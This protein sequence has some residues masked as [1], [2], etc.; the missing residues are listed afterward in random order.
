MNNNS[1][2]KNVSI[3]NLIHLVSHQYSFMKKYRFTLL[4]SSL[5]FL[6]FT[7]CNNAPIGEK[8]V[9]KDA[10]VPTKTAITKY[11]SLP[12]NVNSCIINWQG[13]KKIGGGH[14]GIIFIKDGVALIKEGKLVGGKITINMN[15]LIDSDLSAP[16]D[17]A[18]LEEHLKSDDFF[19]V[20]NYP[21]AT[22]EI[23]K[24]MEDTAAGEGF[25]K[26][27]GNL[28]IKGIAKSI[29]I[30][31]RAGMREGQFALRTSPF[32]INRTDWGIK[33]HSG[34]MGTPKDMII[35]DNIGL[36]IVLAAEMEE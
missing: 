13:T 36:Q 21:A 8:V 1:Q 34:L 15:S 31:A 3:P 20:A 18:E 32:T 11:L 10:V 9:A 35:N 2:Q 16:E 23:T 26:I 19:D 28:T 12:L 27:T 7:A 4:I 24:V 30:P 17:K 22:F 29:E 6:T 25:I 33:F 14:K 5:F